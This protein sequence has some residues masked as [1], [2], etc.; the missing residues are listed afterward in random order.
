MEN[1]EWIGHSS[2]RVCS[3]AERTQPLNSAFRIPH[4]AFHCFRP[5]PTLINTPVTSSDMNRL[6]RP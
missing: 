2:S 5:S 1:A 4:S 6:E 3:T